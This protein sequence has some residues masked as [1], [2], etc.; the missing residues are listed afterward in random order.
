[1]IWIIGIVLGGFVVSAICFEILYRTFLNDL[2]KAIRKGT[3]TEAA[4]KQASAKPEVRNSG[5]PQRTRRAIT[6]DVR[7]GES[8]TPLGTAAATSNRRRGTRT[9]QAII[10]IRLGKRLAVGAHRHSGRYIP[11]RHASG[12]GGDGA[13]ARSIART[14]A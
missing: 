9:R 7:K 4:E 13:D 1:M 12:A 11:R 14:D 2:A 6:A 3:E 10:W 8:V 5:R